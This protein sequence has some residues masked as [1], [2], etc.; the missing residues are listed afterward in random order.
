M[1]VLGNKDSCYLC[2]T[3]EETEALRGYLTCP[4]G[5]DLNRQDLNPGH[6]APKPRL[7]LPFTVTD[8]GLPEDCP[9]EA[10]WA[11]EELA[12]DATSQTL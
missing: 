1:A 8:H 2:F 3:N 11:D 6:L 4:E 12:E 10:A 9:L 5:Q 7:R